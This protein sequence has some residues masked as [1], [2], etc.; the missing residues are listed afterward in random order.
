MSRLAEC[1][2]E[3]DL[4]AA[5]TSGRWPDGVDAALREHVASC[6]VC[7]GRAAGRRGHGRRSNRR[8]WPTRGCRRRVRCG[9]ARRCARGTRPAAVA[10]RPVMVAQALGGAA[11]V[12]LV[13]AVVSWKWA[14]IATVALDLGL[15]AWVGVATA[16]VLG[17]LAIYAAVRSRGGP[18]PLRV[19]LG[20]RSITGQ[21]AWPATR[22]PRRARRPP[23]ACRRDRAASSRPA[24]LS[25]AGSTNTILPLRRTRAARPAPSPSARGTRGDVRR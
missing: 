20:G 16:A 13:A 11:A 1:R 24:W 19:A 17:P 21:A 4:V 15:V 5:V 9:G 10:A 25:S 3:A 8:R 7:C 14:A 23:R 2:H 12:G 22:W 6:A 18:H